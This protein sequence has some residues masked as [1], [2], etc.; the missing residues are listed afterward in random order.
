MN[1]SD[2]PT[3]HPEVPNAPANRV[4]GQTWVPASDGM[5]PGCEEQLTLLQTLSTSPFHRHFLERFLEGL[6]RALGVPWWGVHALLYVLTLALFIG[7]G[8]VQTQ[9]PRGGYLSLIGFATE[10]MATTYLLDYVRRS[11]TEAFLVAARMTFPQE[12]LVWLRRYWGPMHWGWIIPLVSASGSDRSPGRFRRL[13]IRLFGPVIRLRLWVVAV[14]LLGLFYTT[15][16]LGW[17]PGPYGAPTL[18]FPHE[19]CIYTDFAKAVAILVVLT[20]FWMLHGLMRIVWGLCSAALTSPQRTAL[21]RYCQGSVVRISCVAALAVGGW[22]FTYGLD[23]GFTNWSWWW[24]FW[25]AVLFLTNLAILGNR[26][27]RPFDQFE[28]ALQMACAIRARSGPF[29]DFYVPAEQSAL[30]I[31]LLLCPVSL[32]LLGASIKLTDTIYSPFNL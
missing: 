25:L 16:W 14:L 24:S 6:G 3:F 20:N 4:G 31:I 15:L 23:H 27:R 29:K 5:P 28:F 19:L 12:R 17:H 26:G 7:L 22:L 1:D 30:L 21:V 13:L 18:R 11:R 8:H 10:F 2:I 32:N 9:F